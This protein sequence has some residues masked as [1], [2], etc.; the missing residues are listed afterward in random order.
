MEYFLIKDGD[1]LLSDTSFLRR[2]GHANAVPV[3]IYNLDRGGEPDP[4]SPTGWSIISTNLERGVKLP[5][6]ESLTAHTREGIRFAIER[7][8]GLP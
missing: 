3:K 5:Q 7:I 8:R 4:E 6:L 1:K 2:L